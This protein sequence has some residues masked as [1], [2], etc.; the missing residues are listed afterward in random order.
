LTDTEIPALADRVSPAADERPEWR[1]A[2]TEFRQLR[3]FVTVAEELHFGRAAAC[4]YISQPALSQAIAKLESAIGVQLLVRNRQGVELTEAGKEL[5]CRSRSLLNAREEAV[6]RVRLIDRGDVGVLRVG[7]SLFAEHA[8][9]PALA[10][11]G[12]RQPHIALDR[13]VA[14]TDR[15][16]AQLS[17]GMLDAVL[18]HAVPSIIGLDSVDSELVISEQ[19]IALVGRQSP[20]AERTTITIA[21]LRDEQLMIPPR[22][23]APSALI[24]MI[25]M[26]RSF[27]GFEPNLFESAAMGT[28]PLGPEWLAEAGG[29]AVTLAGSAWRGQVCRAASSPC[30]SSR[31]RS[32][33]WR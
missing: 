16:L 7:V 25:S 13:V 4:L 27:G 8:V 33:R 17:S 3:Y 15:L 5:L 30:R 21:D 31:R 23:L 14:V 29:R 12:A 1:A 22:E 2:A 19:M 18:G 24:G 9:S 20:L 26:C 6:N 32:C 10:A 28:A 11:L